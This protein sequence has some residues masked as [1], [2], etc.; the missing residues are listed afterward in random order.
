MRLKAVNCR[1]AHERVLIDGITQLPVAG[2][3]PEMEFKRR[4]LCDAAKRNK[5]LACSHTMAR[6]PLENA[7]DVLERL[8]EYGEWRSELN[9][10]NN[11]IH[12][13]DH[14]KGEAEKQ[15][16]RMIEKMRKGEPEK[17]AD[18]SLDK[19]LFSISKQ[20][21]EMERRHSTYAAKIEKLKNEIL[22]A[23]DSAIHS[24]Q[25]LT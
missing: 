18:C 21:T 8:G 10:L 22:S 5:N 2:V 14:I 17:T 19:E 3:I 9:D 13:L 4:G 7:L 16:A 23:I 20:I 11:G 12:V 15:S 6:Y 25:T 1:M 24:S